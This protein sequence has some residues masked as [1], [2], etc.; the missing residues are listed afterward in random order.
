MKGPFSFLF[1]FLIMNILTGC[2]EVPY[3]ETDCQLDNDETVVDINPPEC[4]VPEQ[5]ANAELTINSTLEDFSLEQENKMKDALKR[6]KVV[7]NSA[8]FKNKVINHS[9][10]GD[11]TF[12]D[13]NGLT[14]EEIY[15]KIMAASET[16]S[17]EED[18]EID[19]DITLYF[20]NNSTVGYT[21]PNVNK[22]WVNRK[23]F[24]T[25]SLAKVAGNVAHEWTHKLGFDHDF[26]RTERRNFSVPYAVGS[27]I[28]ELIENMTPESQSGKNVL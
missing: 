21:Y 14:N 27:I 19:I 8:E 4:I 5:E 23:F 17:P 22:I 26:Q 6:L 24:S 18:H 28:Q 13:N 20:A 2:K 25:Y 12:I 15:Q 7:I 10:N 9:Y 3:T 16:L 1:F 11:K